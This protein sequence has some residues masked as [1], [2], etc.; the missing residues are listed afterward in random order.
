LSGSQP[1]APG[2]A[3]GYLLDKGENLERLGR[4]LKL[5]T[6]VMQHEFSSELTRIIGGGIDLSRFS[7]K[8]LAEFNASIAALFTGSGDQRSLSAQPTV[9]AP[10][11]HKNQR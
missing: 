11:P 3:G 10:E 2:F 5:F 8:E 1:K 6:D 4:H 7:D 9:L